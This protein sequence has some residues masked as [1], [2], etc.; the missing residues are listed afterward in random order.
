MK[1]K[2]GFSQHSYQEGT[3]LETYEMKLIQKEF[4]QHEISVLSK[5]RSDSGQS[6]KMIE[7]KGL[8]YLVFSSLNGLVEKN[9]FA[10]VSHALSLGKEVFYIENHDV[11]GCSIVLFSILN[12]SDDEYAVI[13]K[14]LYKRGY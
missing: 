9:V 7:D 4:P 1:K 13:K 2:I 14:I 10:E 5:S 8:E 3:P 12:E 11:K 6:L